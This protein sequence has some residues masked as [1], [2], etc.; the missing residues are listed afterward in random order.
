MNS[1]SRGS[2]QQPIPAETDGIAKKI[3]HAAF[4]VH[5]TLGPGLLESVYET[6]MTYELSK[7]GL[8][9]Q[10]QVMLP[11]YYDGIRLDAGLRLDMLVEDQVIV[12]LKAVE[13]IRPVHHAQTLTYLKLT[14]YRLALLIN[15]NEVLIKQGIK[16]IAL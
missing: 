7:S 6:C 14:S 9:V 10:R 4:V 3:V 13:H 11:V 5:K 15:F 16:R 12:E 2:S 1:H 8:H